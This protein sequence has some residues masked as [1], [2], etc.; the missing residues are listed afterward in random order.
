[1]NIR[2]GQTN[3]NLISSNEDFLGNFG[4][5]AYFGYTGFFRG[6][7]KSLNVRNSY[8][9]ESI[10]SPSFDQIWNFAGNYGQTS[11]RAPA[12]SAL[13]LLIGFS[14]LFGYASPHFKDTG[15]IT[16]SI[17][18]DP[19]C[20]QAVSV[21]NPSTFKLEFSIFNCNYAGTYRV[22]TSYNNVLTTVFPLYTI[23]ARAYEKLTIFNG[24]NKIK[25]IGGQNFLVSD[26]SDTYPMDLL[27]NGMISFMATVQDIFN[28][29]FNL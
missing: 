5:W 16:W 23:V 22:K 29:I 6:S 7:S 12:S 9:C 10:I 21:A 20:G 2:W 1:M 8:A 4:G 17:T 24:N 13:S 18:V 15:L 28:N 25:L 3:E 26:S 27:N 11:A 14:D 19:E